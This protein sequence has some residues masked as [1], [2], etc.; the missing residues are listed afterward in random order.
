[1]LNPSRPFRQQVL[2][3]LFTILNEELQGE[4]VRVYLFGSWARQEEKRS[5]DIDIAVSYDESQTSLDW[6]SLVERVEESTIPYRVQLV[7]TQDAN[8]ALIEE[9]EREGIVW[10]DY[11]SD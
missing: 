5:S 7:K 8:Q 1:M 2:G 11:K 9:I 10:I 4:S 6:N 3:Q